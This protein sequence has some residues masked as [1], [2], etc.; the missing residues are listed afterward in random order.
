MK[1]VLLKLLS[2][3]NAPVNTEEVSL[4]D[5]ITVLMELNGIVVGHT[6]TEAAMLSLLTGVTERNNLSRGG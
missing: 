5:C 4:R 2:L 6:K 3:D 1:D